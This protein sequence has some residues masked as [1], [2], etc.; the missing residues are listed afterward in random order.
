MLR[1]VRGTYLSGW[2]LHGTVPAEHVLST[3]RNVVSI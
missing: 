1:R 3:K 2:Y